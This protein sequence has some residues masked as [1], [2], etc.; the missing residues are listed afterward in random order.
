MTNGLDGS[1]ARVASAS[2]ASH[3]R[4]VN[5][6]GDYW[7]K[8]RCNAEGNRGRT[9]RRAAVPW[10]VAEKEVDATTWR[11]KSAVAPNAHGHRGSPGCLPTNAAT[12]LRRLR[13]CASRV[14]PVPE[15]VSTAT[16]QENGASSG[17]VSLPTR[18]W[19]VSRL[20]MHALWSISAANCSASTRSNLP[21]VRS[22]IVE[23]ETRRLMFC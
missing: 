21:R 9:S 23:N 1:E 17:I 2:S 6:T 13:A 3:A 7:H 8:G 11:R 10:R 20:K 22:P 18:R 12:A 15:H 5:F 19:I 16:R 4:E 14:D